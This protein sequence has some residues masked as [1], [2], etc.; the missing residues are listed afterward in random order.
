MNSTINECWQLTDYQLERQNLL[1]RYILYLKTV[2][3]KWF[4]L[5]HISIQFKQSEK[6]PTKKQRLDASQEDDIPDKRKKL[7]QNVP[8]GKHLKMTADLVVKYLTPYF[9]AKKIASKVKKKVCEFDLDHVG[10]LC[11]HYKRLNLSSFLNS[12]FFFS[13]CQNSLTYPFPHSCIVFII[14]LLDLFLS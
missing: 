6:I 9:S 12:P 7:E 10:A 2:L 3:Q 8:D 4:N 14:I 11:S 5:K 1:C 13:G